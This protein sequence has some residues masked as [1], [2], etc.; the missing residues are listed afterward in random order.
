MS[1]K[2][3]KVFQQ[4]GVIPYRLQ[5]GSLEVLL[6]TTR[7]R[8]NW[9]VPKGGVIDGMSPA[10]SAAKEAWEEAGVVGQVYT[11]ELDT[12]K[13]RKKG[14]KYEVKMF[15]L[16]VETVLEDYPEV[17]QRQRQWLD[18]NKAIRR[19]KKPSIKRILKDFLE[20]N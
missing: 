7:N 8:Q 2:V 11:H 5:N 10:I 3:S 4:S 14:K 9:V 20:P 6:I 13:Y 16:S 17:G 15:L 1:R 19:V 18:I 12:Y